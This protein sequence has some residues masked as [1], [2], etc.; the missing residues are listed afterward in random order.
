[1]NFFKRKFFRFYVDFLKNRGND[2]KY[3]KAQYYLKNEQ[4]IDL[5]EPR[6]FMEKI[7]WLKLFYYTEAYKDF[8]DKYEVRK[9]V[10]DRAGEQV[11]NEIYG[12]YN[13]VEEIDLAELPKQFVLKCTHASGT[14]IIVKDKDTLNWKKAKV[15]LKKWMK[16][17]Y[18]AKSR[19]LIYKDIQPRIIAEKYL[20]QL[21]EGVID[22]KFYCFHGKPEYVL[23][24]LTEDGVDKKCYY[25]M[26]WKKVVPDKLTKSF[27]SKDIE[28]PAN[29]E[30]MKNIALKLAEGFIFVR[31]D[32]YSIEG[33]TLF[34]EMTF[35]PTGGIKRL[36]IESMNRQLGD[37]MRLPA[38]T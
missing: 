21:A 9:Y 28:Q 25:T 16:Q 10:K 7:S 31:I 18:Y 36:A 3:I 32:L 34:G 20:S 38:R 26:D 1:M 15:Q 17:N 5:D 29:F 2:I 37:L 30:E 6:E 14:N 27:L 8:A 35:F 4:A 24:K 11:L 19:E 22:Y 13:T 33:R 12:I 23:V